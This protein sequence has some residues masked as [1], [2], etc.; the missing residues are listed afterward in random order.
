MKIRFRTPMKCDAGHFMYL[1]NSIEND[2]IKTRQGDKQLDCNCESFTRCGDDELAL[3]L[4]DLNGEQVYE[5]D[6]VVIIG[7]NFEGFVVYKPPQFLVQ[8]KTQI[9][10]LV[11]MSVEVVGNQWWMVNKESE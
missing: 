9:H 5:G 7:R 6:K 1:F 10:L 4:I 11:G 3:D 2:G 8:S